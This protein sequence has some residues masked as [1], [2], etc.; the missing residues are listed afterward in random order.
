MADLLDV[1]LRKLE[2]AWELANRI[3][4]KEPSTGGAWTE[5]DYLDRAQGVLTQ[6]REVVNSVFEKAHLVPRA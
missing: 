5:K 4:P 1:Q 3:I 2:M 6:A